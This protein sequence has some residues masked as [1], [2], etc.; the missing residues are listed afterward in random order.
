VIDDDRRLL[1]GVRQRDPRALEELYERHKGACYALAQRVLND[2]QASEEAVQDAFVAVWLRVQTFRAEAGSVR[3]WIIAI[4]RNAA[5]DRLRKERGPRTNLPLFDS[6]LAE[7]SS[8][9]EVAIITDR[10]VMAKALSRLPPE[11]RYVLELAYFGGYS[12]P[13]I[14]QAL[15]VPVGTIKSRIRLT[16]EKLRASI[17]MDAV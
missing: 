13:E 4:T 11:Q 8:A 17:E 5:I 15:D 3:T 12:Y 1:D 16:L 14:A 7:S 2:W 9:R 10:Q 6:V